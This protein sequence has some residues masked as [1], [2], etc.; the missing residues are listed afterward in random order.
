MLQ[1]AAAALMLGLLWAALDGARALHLLARAE[2]G[3]LGAALLA[4][5]AQTVLS[6]WRWRVTAGQLGQTI[7]LPRA[8]SE[9]YLAQVV[10][11][12]LPGGVLGDAG[13]VLRARHGT[14]LAR[15]GAAVAV[16]RL[17]GQI[18]LFL[19]LLAGMIFMGL[20]PGGMAMPPWVLV[21]VGM[22][23]TAGLAMAAGIACTGRLSGR[24]GRVARDLRRV[25]RVTLFSR[26]ALPRQILLNLAITF[27][28]VA[29]FAF[30]AR[31]IGTVLSPGQATVLVPLILLTMI[32]PLTISGWG[33]R[34]GAAAGLFPLAGAS[35]QAGLAASLAFGLVF[36]A[37]TLPGLLVL[38]A[39][40]PKPPQASIAQADP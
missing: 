15:A 25:L 4:L 11:Q 17:A 12:S 38:L 6:A 5:T 2:P 37:S 30:C 35:A 34:E 22:L 27:A 23:L 39:C 1:I 31:S 14:G 13:R 32:L 8:I 36:L 21:L 26:Q 19:V 16:E 33:L 9:Y 29:A 7:P 3:W 24:A 10:N 28:N 18:T 40:R 20:A